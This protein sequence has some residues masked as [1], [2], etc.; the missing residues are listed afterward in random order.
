MI[1]M[2]K[3]NTK[4]LCKDT[5]ENLTKDFPGGSYLV[6]ERKSVVSGDRMLI[7][8]GYNYNTWKVLSLIST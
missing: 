7:S 1:G 4:V 6:L 3:T 8:I 2:V 5:I